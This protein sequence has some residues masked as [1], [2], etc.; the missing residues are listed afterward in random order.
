MT[1]PSRCAALWTLTAGAV[2]ADWVAV[3]ARHRRAE[4]VAKP[5]AMLALGSAALA[6]GLHERPWGR[7]VLGGLGL[8]LV[9]DV[10]LLRGEQRG[11]FLGGLTS[12]LLGH[13]AYLDATRRMGLHRTAWVLPGGLVLAGCLWSSREVL[14]ALAAEG[15]LPA[16]AP[17]AAYMAVIG[18]T[19]LAAWSTQDVVLGTGSSLFVLSDT[20]L[21]RDA[22]VAP[23]PAAGVRVMVPYLLAQ[24]LV[25]VGALRHARGQR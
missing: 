2:A 11:Y 22:F 1:R 17:V 20:V 21:A 6:S 10:A 13:L 23:V 16:A 7:S 12:F 4:V 5:G 8:G 24:T 9:G 25:V 19:S 14:P 3:A 18:A 15:G